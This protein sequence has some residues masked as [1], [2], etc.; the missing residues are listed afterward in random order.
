MIAAGIMH[1]HRTLT[2][3]DGS[4]QRPPVGCYSQAFL[5]RRAQRDLLRRSVWNTLTPQMAIL[6]RATG[7]G[8]HMRRGVRIDVRVEIHP[9]SVRRPGGRRTGTLRSHLRTGG[10]SVHR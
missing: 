6:A 1:P 8:A 7:D 3:A 10:A 5:L 4:D 9:P 2:A